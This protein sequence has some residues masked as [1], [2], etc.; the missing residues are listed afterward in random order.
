LEFWKKLP[1]EINVLKYDSYTTEQTW[2]AIESGTFRQANEKD[3]KDVNEDKN[4]KKSNDTI[5]EVSELKNTDLDVIHIVSTF[6]QTVQDVNKAQDERFEDNL[7]RL[8]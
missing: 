2:L 6:N 3:V 8:T 7:I 1:K 5:E 4:V